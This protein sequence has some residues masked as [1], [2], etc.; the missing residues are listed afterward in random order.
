MSAPLRRKDSFDLYQVWTVYKNSVK[1]SALLALPSIEYHREFATLYLRIFESSM[2]IQAIQQRSIEDHRVRPR[3]LAQQA[4]VEHEHCIPG[5]VAEEPI[6]DIPEDI[7]RQPIHQD[8]AIAT[9]LPPQPPHGHHNLVVDPDHEARVA[10]PARVTL[11][12]H[13]V[14]PAL[15]PELRPGP[16]RFLPK[17]VLPS[18]NKDSAAGCGGHVC[19]DLL[20]RLLLHVSDEEDRLPFQGDGQIEPFCG[21]GALPVSRVTEIPVYINHGGFRMQENL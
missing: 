20:A 9:E 13:V 6:V 15:V 4:A 7:N 3:L 5:G 21:L 10:H 12:R 16:V 11:D 19:V 14:G 1:E 17:Y 8:R 18:G 2:R